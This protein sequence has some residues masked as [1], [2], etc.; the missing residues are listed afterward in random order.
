MIW[1]GSLKVKRVVMM[2]VC[3]DSDRQYVLSDSI[4]LFSHI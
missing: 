1:D 4:H 3:W 2:K